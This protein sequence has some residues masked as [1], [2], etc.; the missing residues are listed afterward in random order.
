MFDIFMFKKFLGLLLI[1]IF[2]LS[3]VFNVN[4]VIDADKVKISSCSRYATEFTVDFKDINGN[5]LSDLKID[6]GDIS[7]DHEFNI[8]DKID[9]GAEYMIFHIDPSDGFNN[10]W[11]ATFKL[12]A[13]YFN[14]HGA[15]GGDP[16]VC[17]FL[18]DGRKG[19][20][21]F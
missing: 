2:V 11:N 18:D 17:W 12:Q 13:A 10:K 9:K 7:C 14:F 5:D 1:S 6:W 21:H 8:K 15:L 3:I 19:C 20:H 4:A 16:R